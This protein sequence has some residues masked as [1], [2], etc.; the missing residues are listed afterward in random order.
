[1][2]RLRCRPGAITR[3][4]A[5]AFLTFG[6]MLQT[7]AVCRPSAGAASKLETNNT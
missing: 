3:R 2:G 7:T 1:V 5:L 6:G 4:P